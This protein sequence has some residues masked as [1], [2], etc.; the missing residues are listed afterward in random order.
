MASDPEADGTS[1]N[2][3][4]DYDD[5]AAAFS[6]MSSLL[7]PEIALSD[8]NFDDET[9]DDGDATEHKIDVFQMN[10]EGG[11]RSYKCDVCGKFFKRKAH[12]RRHY[13]LHTGERPYECH[14]CGKSFARS[15]Q[16]NQHIAR[17][18]N[19]SNSIACTIC[20]K[21][22]RSDEERMN[23]MVLH[24]ENRYFRCTLC[25]KEFDKASALAGH[26]QVHTS[27]EPITV[28]KKTYRCATCDMEFTRFDHLIRHQ[29]VH[30]GVK[31]HQ[32]KFCMKRFTRADNRTKHEKTCRIAKTTP[33]LSPMAATTS[34]AFN[35]ESG[36]NENDITIKSEPDSSVDPLEIINVSS[37]P[38][39]FF[40]D[41]DT[42]NNTDDLLDS[43]D[44]FNEDDG[45]QNGQNGLQSVRQP[46]KLA[47]AAGSSGT[48][49][50]MEYVRMKQSEADQDLKKL[51]GIRQKVERPKLTAEEIRT[52]T[53]NVCGK[54]LAQKYHLVRHKII[55][56][57]QKPYKCLRCARSFARREHLR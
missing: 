45:T 2:G 27:N 39:H 19:Q 44:L 11:E 50:P 18:H 15:E 29:T 28:A 3:D 21:T 38:E 49:N 6:P 55:H 4:C 40:E 30:S 12:L 57:K 14:H 32:C 7:V 9:I 10:G 43:F 13:R 34:S 31:Q 56:L 54:T 33:S 51:G 53:C 1:L 20:N 41:I 26:M 23:H 35:N 24:L 52:L 48:I 46:S 8:G 42:S 16:R 22:F 37:I 47:A 36:D 25:P 17:E 5:D